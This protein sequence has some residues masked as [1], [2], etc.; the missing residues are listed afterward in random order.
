MKTKRVRPVLVESKDIHSQL[1]IDNIY[2]NKLSYELKQYHCKHPQEL[3]LISL[4]DEEIEVGNEYLD[5]CGLIRKA[6]TSDEDYWKRRPDYKKVIARQSQISPEYISKFIE[7]YNNDCVE[8]LE[9]EMEELYIYP[10]G[11]KSKISRLMP[12]AKP[13]EEPNLTNGFVTIVEKE[14][15]YN[16]LSNMQYYM[17]Y[18][19]ANGYVTPQDWLNKF[20]HYSDRKEPIS[21]TEEEVRKLISEALYHFCPMNNHREEDEIDWFENNKKK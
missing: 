3:I 19:Q 1:E 17:E 16:L 21:Y 13:V 18:C 5:D 4:E 7:Q 12:D 10:D 9:I 15:S 2:I 6:V 8:D 14:Y 20:K 11:T